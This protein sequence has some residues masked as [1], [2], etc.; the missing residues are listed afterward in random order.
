[1]NRHAEGMTG[2]SRKR[3]PV[4]RSREVFRVLDGSHGFR[5]S[6]SSGRAAGRFEGRRAERAVARDGTRRL[7]DDSAAAIPGGAGGPPVDPH[8]P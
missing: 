7:I 8:L 2:W 5:S 6:R 1:M 4:G 3:L